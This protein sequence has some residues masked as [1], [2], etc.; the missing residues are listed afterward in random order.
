MQRTSEPRLLL[1]D[2]H[3]WLWLAAGTELSADIR[4]AIAVAA[5]NGCLRVA[6][7]SIWEIALLAS[8]RRITL[9]K[10]TPEWFNEALAAPGLAIEPLSPEIAVESY[11]LPDPFHNDPADRMIAATARVTGAV[12]MTRDRQILDF[13]GR[14]HLTVIAV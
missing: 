10:P 3:V 2:T 9:G 7:I 11:A 12:L 5:S 14:G 4:E 1:L 8:R 6:A 13:A